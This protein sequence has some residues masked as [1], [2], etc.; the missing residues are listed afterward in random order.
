MSKRKPFKID[1]SDLL[2][3]PANKTIIRPKS[4]GLTLEN[5]G[6][7][8]QLEY[9]ETY[10]QKQ[11]PANQEWVMN[12]VQNVIK[13]L[14]GSLGK[15]HK[16]LYSQI[17][18]IKKGYVISVFSDDVFALLAVTMASLLAFGIREKDDSNNMLSLTETVLK[19][20]AK[21]NMVDD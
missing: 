2:N 18:Q 19:W 14:S 10:N 5:R 12:T 16:Y 17:K 21:A 15:H 7:D 4:I 3:I 20:I 13:E 8:F 9:Q 1:L 6:K 11:A